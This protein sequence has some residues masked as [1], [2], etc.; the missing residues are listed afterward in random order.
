MNLQQGGVQ[1]DHTKDFAAYRVTDP[2]TGEPTHA[3]C[4]NNKH[5]IQRYRNGAR[6]V[7]LPRL[8]FEEAKKPTPTIEG[9]KQMTFWGEDDFPV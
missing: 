5:P 4:N 9:A 8:R 6:S 1:Y 7:A 2:E 3:F